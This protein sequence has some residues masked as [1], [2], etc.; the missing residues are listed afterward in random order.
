MG[1][2]LNIEIVAN[3]KLLANCYYHWSAYT[4][5]AKI[6]TR[7]ILLYLKRSKLKDPLLK[8]IRCLET[9][10]AG[11]TEFEL[12]DAKELYP[13]KKFKKATDRNDGLI[14]ITQSEMNKTRR[15]EESRVTIDITNN[16][17]NFDVFFTETI[18]E[19]K[20]DHMLSEDITILN[21]KND[22]CIITFDDFLINYE[23]FGKD[24]IIYDNIVYQPIG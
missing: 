21:C 5:S 15:W 22:P 4:S 2:R 9:T 11:L 24:C 10:G 23:N 7:Q 16:V 18:E 20:E 8:A 1:Q 12:E 14:A 13:N 6:L 19:F 17:I 3:D